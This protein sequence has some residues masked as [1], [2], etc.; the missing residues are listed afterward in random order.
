M[1]TQSQY[2]LDELTKLNELYESNQQHLQLEIEVLHEELKS[3]S[4][5][6]IHTIYMSLTSLHVQLHLVNQFSNR[7]STLLDN[8]YLLTR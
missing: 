7:I 2:L 5:D 3:A 8:H 4:D 1:N 6:N